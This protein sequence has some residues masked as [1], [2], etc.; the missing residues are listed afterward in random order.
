MKWRVGVVAHIVFAFALITA[1]Q[2]VYDDDR[3]SVPVPSGW[4]INPVTA[5]NVSA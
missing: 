2:Q 1:A 5:K 4:S 3:I